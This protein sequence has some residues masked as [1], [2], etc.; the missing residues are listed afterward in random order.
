[1]PVDA[2]VL[3]QLDTASARGVGMAGT[4]AEQHAMIIVAAAQNDSRLMNGFLAD[5][6]FQEDVMQSK[7]AWGTPYSGGGVPPTPPKPA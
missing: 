7:S 6:L 2:T 4:F 3:S 5:Q 1:M